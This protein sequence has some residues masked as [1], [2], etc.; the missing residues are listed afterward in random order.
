MT[1]YDLAA[2]D[3]AGTTID[4]DGIV[5][6]VLEETV[7]AAIGRE[8]PA[9][10]MAAWKGTAKDEAMVGILV[11]LAEDA[12]PARVEKIYADFADRL[13][14][15]Y[16]ETPPRPIAGVPE[17]FAVLR[18]RGVKVVLQTGYDLEVASLILDAV[19]WEVGRDIDALITSDQVAASRPAPYMV[20]RAMEAVGVLDVRRV[21]TAGDTPNDLAAGWN[22]GAGFV[23]GVTTGAFSAEQLAEHE[24]THILSSTADLPSLLG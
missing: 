5:Y 22:A 17:A 20:F 9:E 8:V 1:A 2:L 21:L 18:D 23:V 7:S 3:M 13:K 14:A 10:V 4:E 11:D 19:A 24:H 16:R 15:A 12:S 6:R